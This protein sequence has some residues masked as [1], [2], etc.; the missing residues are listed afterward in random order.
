MKSD[1]SVFELLSSTPLTDLATKIA[2]KSELVSTDAKK[3]E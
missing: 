2:T 3:A 1:I